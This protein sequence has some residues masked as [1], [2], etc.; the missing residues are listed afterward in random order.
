LKGILHSAGIADDATVLSIDWSKFESVF[1]AKVY[2]SWNLHL[3]TKD[4]QL[5]FCVLYP[6]ITNFGDYISLKTHNY[7]SIAAV[8]GNA[9]QCNYA[10]ANFFMDALA[11]YRY[12]KKKGKEKVNLCLDVELDC[13]DLVS[14]GVHGRRLG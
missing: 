8:L 7:S 14:T 11:H 12:H 9:G 5:D 13:Q 3:L 10:A 4:L 1:G 6:T 2:G